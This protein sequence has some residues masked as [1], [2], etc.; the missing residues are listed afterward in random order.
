MNRNAA[1][2]PLALT[3]ALGLTITVVATV[4]GHLGLGPGFDP[5]TLTISDYALSNRG[6]AIEVA[7]VALIVGSLALLG[8]LFAARAPVRGAPAVLICLWALGLLTATVIPTDPPGME[9]MSTAAYIHRYASVGAFLCLPIAA[10]I[11]AARFKRAAMWAGLRNRMYTLVAAS[12]AGLIGLWYVAFPGERV[13][14]GLVERGL[15][16]VEI[17]L[18]SLLTARLFMVAK[19]RRTAPVSPAPRTQPEPHTEPEQR[20]LAYASADPSPA[21]WASSPAWVRLSQ[22]SLTSNRDT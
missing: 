19:I 22:S 13:A 9:T 16:G 14:I 3:A 12:G 5:L 2:R 20:P 15:V 4:I 7:M 11:L 18:L 21:S 10:A 1:I 17:V 8:G 6:G